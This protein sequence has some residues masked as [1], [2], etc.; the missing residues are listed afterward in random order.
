MTRERMGG[1]NFHRERDDDFGRAMHTEPLPR[2]RWID[3]RGP[4]ILA[5][6]AAALAGTAIAVNWQA[7]RMERRHPPVGKFVTV[8]GVRL[9]YLEAGEGPPVVLLHGNASM[10]NDVALGLLE[11]LSRKYRVIAFDR[12]GFGYSERPRNRVWS[13]EAQAA[14]FRDA[15]RLL[16]LD[17]P[18]LYGHSFGAVVVIT[19]AVHHPAETRGVVPASGYYYPIRR[20]DAAIAWMNDLP[21]IGRVL[22]NT[23]TPVQGLM[24]GN[25]AVRFLFD[26][27]PVSRAYESFPAG[28]ALRPEQLRAAAE[29]GTTLR[30]WA[31]RTEG[32]YRDVQVPVVVV[33]GDGDRVV[34]Y[35][36]HSLRLSREIPG[37][38]LRLVPGSGHMVHHTRPGDVIKAIDAAFAKA[39]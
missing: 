13:P 35:Q 24:L 33:S 37:A 30:A 5:G 25:L 34:G 11:P 27:A 1:G 20:L 23:L 36:D 15:F 28:L 21:V 7:R 38:E 39:E 16:G 3:G 31:K 9:H 26:P 8:N 6:I 12:P 29:D 19:F 22:R 17:R 10:L 14:L 4:L 32:L 2:R 18:V